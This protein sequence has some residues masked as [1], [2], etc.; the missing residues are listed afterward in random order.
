VS[1][2]LADNGVNITALST[3]SRPEPESGTPIFTM[4][5]DMAVPAGT[6]VRALRQR[7][8][9]VADE[10]HVELALSDRPNED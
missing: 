4:R 7:L 3:Q 2:T 8:E 10:L 1:R 9:R 5:I 6:D